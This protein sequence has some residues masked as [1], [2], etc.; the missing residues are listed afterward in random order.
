MIRGFAILLMLGIQCGAIDIPGLNWQQ[1]SD[2]INVRTNIPNAIGDGIADDTAALQS[3]LNATNS[4]K[5]IYLPAGTYRITQTLAMHNGV[6]SSIIGNGRDTK[7]VWGG[8]VGGAMFW[9]DTAVE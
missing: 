6:A 7:I 1:R 3:A 9:S 5:T 4:G 2:W 8:A